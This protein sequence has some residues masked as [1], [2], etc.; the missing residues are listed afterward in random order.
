MKKQHRQ[1]SPPYFLYLMI[2]ILI[3]YSYYIID[4]YSN[5]KDKFYYEEQIYYVHTGDTLWSIGQKYKSDTDDIREWMSKVK[6]I[7]NMETSD[8]VAGT[9]II[10]LV[11]SEE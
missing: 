8:I 3:I 9:K 11:N 1:K 2:L 5:A 4:Q 6:E 10:I 7:N